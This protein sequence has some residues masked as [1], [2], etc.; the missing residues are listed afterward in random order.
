MS[1]QR[2]A[3]NKLHVTGS[4]RRAAT[5][6]QDAALLARLKEEGVL[7]PIIVT[8]RGDGTYDVVKGKRRVKLAQ[9]AKLTDVP[10]V[11]KET[12]DPYEMGTLLNM[13][14]APMRDIDVADYVAQ[15]FSQKAGIDHGEVAKTLR[16]I[17][18]APES[19]PEAVR[20]ISRLTKHLGLGAWE[21]YVPGMLK[22]LNLPENVLSPLRDGAITAQQAAVLRGVKDEEARAALTAEAGDQDMSA[23]DIRNAIKERELNPP[24]ETKSKDDESGAP[25]GIE[26][27]ENIISGRLDALSEGDRKRVRNLMSQMAKIFRKARK[28]QAE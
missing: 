20:V 4:A 1:E 8:P 18:K 22:L 26:D 19:N 21:D 5:H 14:Q 23:K 27:A 17:A 12:S 16:E 6:E 3:L 15:Q 10:Y 2:I 25:T 24:K 7:V 13:L 9:K 11:V 28:E